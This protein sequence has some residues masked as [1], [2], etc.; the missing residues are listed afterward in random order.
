MIQAILIILRA[1][2]ERSQRAVILVPD[3]AYE[4][5]L[6]ALGCLYPNNT[7]RTAQMPNGE[8]VSLMTPRTPVEDAGEKFDLYLSGWG[9]ATPHEERA[10]VNWTEKATAV[11]TEIS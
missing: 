10:M 11:Y 2:Q 8:L 9:K 6:K 7:G 4:E 1:A 3:A 5:S